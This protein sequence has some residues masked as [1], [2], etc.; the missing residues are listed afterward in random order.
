[1]AGLSHAGH[2]CYAIAPDVEGM[3]AQLPGATDQEAFRTI[4]E[5]AIRRT[6]A[7]TEELGKAGVSVGLYGRGGAVET[8][9]RLYARDQR[10]PGWT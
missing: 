7:L 10:S 2:R 1:V 3:Y 6:R 8:V 9:A 5:P 4:L